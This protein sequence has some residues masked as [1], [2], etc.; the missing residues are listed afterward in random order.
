M[1]NKEITNQIGYNITG[2]DNN[3]MSNIMLNYGQNGEKRLGRSSKRL[4][5][6]AEIGLLWPN[7]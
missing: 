7:S 3:R 2:M 4:L 1:R 6:G 5:E